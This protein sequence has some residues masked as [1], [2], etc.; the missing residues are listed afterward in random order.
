[1]LGE[2]SSPNNEDQLDLH[3][4]IELQTNFQIRL[5]KGLLL[6]KHVC[7]RNQQYRTC[8]IEFIKFRTFVYLSRNESCGRHPCDESQANTDW[9][10]VS[11]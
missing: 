9:T 11:D 7:I 4:F 3:C 5:W 6:H 8:S 2:F 1:M 10:P